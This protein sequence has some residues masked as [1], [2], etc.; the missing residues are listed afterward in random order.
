MLFTNMLKTIK[1][2]CKLAKSIDAVVLSPSSFP[3]VAVQLYLVSRIFRFS[4]GLLILLLVLDLS[5]LL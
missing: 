5:F 1:I 2:I 4:H 3:M